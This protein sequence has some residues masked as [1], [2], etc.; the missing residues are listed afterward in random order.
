MT[1]EEAFFNLGILVECHGKCDEKYAE[2]LR[3]LKDRDNSSRVCG[4]TCPHCGK[5]L[6]VILEK[7]Q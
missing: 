1:D 3:V 7:S 6:N 4:P 5:W 2:A